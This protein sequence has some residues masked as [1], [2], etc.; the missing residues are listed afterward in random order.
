MAQ[1]ITPMA[2]T[3]GPAEYELEREQAG[4]ATLLRHAASGVAFLPW[5]RGFRLDKAYRYDGAGRNVS[6][7]YTSGPAATISVYV[8]PHG[9]TGPF[10]RFDATFDV[11]VR[12]ML[13]SFASTSWTNERAT[14]FAHPSGDVVP[15]R[16][17]EA[18]GLSQ[19]APAQPC[20]ALVE[21]FA[22]RGWMLKFRAT[23]HAESRA[24][25]DGFLC[26]WLASSGFGGL[27]PDAL[28]R[29]RAAG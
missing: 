15:G 4:G 13:A 9:G 17:V 3:A 27:L 23:Y 2:W 1:T 6:A 8:F 24:E 25:V 16:R 22:H 5:H 21:L 18:R 29:R 14:A 19:A 7:R 26:A 12:D 10:D 20:H 28:T 11:S